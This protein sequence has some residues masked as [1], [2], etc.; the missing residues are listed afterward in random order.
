MK[1]NAFLRDMNLGIRGDDERRIEVLAQDLPCFKG[2]QLAVDITFA[3][4]LKDSS[5]IT[6][7]PSG[8]GAARLPEG[9][10]HSQLQFCRSTRT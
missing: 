2:A 9:G 7:R 10:V 6:A 3:L 5:S 8:I 1:F 4:R